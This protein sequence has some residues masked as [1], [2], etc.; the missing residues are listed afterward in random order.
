MLFLI[1]RRTIATYHRPV[2]EVILPGREHQRWC[3][4]LQTT[5]LPK[6]DCSTTLPPSP[7]LHA[8]APRWGV[9]GMPGCTERWGPRS[10]PALFPS[11]PLFSLQRPP[12]RRPSSCRGS[13]ASAPDTSPAA[14]YQK[15][16]VQKAL[17]SEK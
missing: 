10:G 16:R 12:A 8:Q 13:Q 4:M 15:D 11:A 9:V 17:G 3:Q 6:L 7:C 14:F 2:E 5:A 1:E